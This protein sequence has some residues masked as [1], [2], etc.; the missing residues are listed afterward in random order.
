M[1]G[2]LILT[3]GLRFNMQHHVLNMLVQPFFSWYVRLVRTYHNTVSRSLKVLS[4]VS[5]IQNYIVDPLEARNLLDEV[6]AATTSA[7]SA[8]SDG[9]PRFSGDTKGCAQGHCNF[10]TVPLMLTLQ[11]LEDLVVNSACLCLIQL[12][13]GML[14]D[15]IC[16]VYMHSLPGKCTLG[17]KSQRSLIPRQFITR[18]S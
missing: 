5:F 9:L 8:L 18:M 3:K 16:C 4:A 12:S 17:E 1:D 7:L 13:V 2:S 15:K 14:Y 11:A 6:I 10:Y